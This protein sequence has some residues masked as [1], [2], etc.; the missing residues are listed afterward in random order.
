MP[1]DN[2]RSKVYAA[3]RTTSMWK[4]GHASPM[5]HM[6]DVTKF[7]A[8]VLNS[9]AWLKLTDR[10]Y[11]PDL[12]DGRRNT[13]AHGG[14]NELVFP[15]WSRYPLVILHELSHCAVQRIYYWHEPAFHGPEFCAIYLKLVGRFM[16]REARDEL[17]AAFKA[18]RVRT[19]RKAKRSFT[20]EQREAL[21]QRGLAL[22]ASRKAPIKA[23][24]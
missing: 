3:E 16:G 8:K 13:R 15:R 4:A 17:K 10:A 12:K 5:K 24:A 21:R 18:G 1:R 2:Q 9:K 22:A 20:P 19:R 6:D 14:A 11:M 23:A 7:V